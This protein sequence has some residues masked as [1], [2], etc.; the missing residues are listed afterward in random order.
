MGVSGGSHWR[1]WNRESCDLIPGLK[2]LIPP[3]PF[4][5]GVDL[6]LLPHWISG[7]SRRGVRRLLFVHRSPS[8]L[9][10][11][12]LS[13]P[14]EPVF[15]LRAVTCGALGLLCVGG[16][17]PGTRGW[18]WQRPWPLPWKTLPPSLPQSKSGTM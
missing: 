8:D 5:N 12:T 9:L 1:V 17:N 2:P 4:L 13:L 16:T 15:V 10:A 6:T 14:R 7:K 18:L 3:P 11:E